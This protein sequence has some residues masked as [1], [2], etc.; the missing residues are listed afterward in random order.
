MFVMVD[1]VIE[2]AVRKSCRYGEYES[3]EHLLF[4]FGGLGVI[5]GRSW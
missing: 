3:S 1:Y 4:L 2:M 5:G